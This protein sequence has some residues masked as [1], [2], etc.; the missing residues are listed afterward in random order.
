VIAEAIKRS[1]AQLVSVSENIDETPSGM[2]LHGI[3]ASIAEFYSLNLAAE[4]MKGTTEKA[5][6]GGTPGRPP[7]GYINAREM[8]DGREI[9]TIAIDPDRGQHIAAA[10]R[11]YSTGSYSLSELAG[12]LE[13]RGLR[14]RPRRRGGVPGQVA[15]NR[16]Q[17]ILRNDY[18]IGVLRYAGIV[19]VGRHPKLIDEPTF[20]RV[21]EILDSQRQSGERCWRHHS[22]LRGTVYCG[23]CGGRLIYTKATGR[24]GGTYEYL[25]CSRRLAGICAQPY[26]RLEAVEEA[27]AREYATIRLSGQQRERIRAAVRERVSSIEAAAEPELEELAQKLNEL[28]S[29][30]KKLLQ[31]HY[32]DNISPELFAA[33]QRR[34]RADRVA[35]EVRT[36]QLEADHS[37]ILACMETALDLTDRIEFAY[38]QADPV[39]RRLFNQA[40]FERIWIDRESV[41]GTELTSPMSEVLTI[42]HST[43][44]DPIHTSEAH[45]SESAVSSHRPESGSNP[46]QKRKNLHGNSVPWRFERRFYGAPERTRTSTDPTVHKP[47]KLARLPNSATSALRTAIIAVAGGAMPRC[48]GKLP[49]TVCRPRGPLSY[50]QMFVTDQ[51]EPEREGSVKLTR[52][53]R[54]ILEF[55]ERYC[56]LNGYPPTVRDIGKAVGLA[57]SST[58]HAHLANLEKLGMLRRDPTKPRAI[59][60]RGR[61]GG[62]LPRRLRDALPLVGQVAA[63]QPILAE[64]NIEE[65]VD[66]PAL[67]GGTEGDFLLRIRGESMKNAGILDGDVVVVRRQEI[68]QDGE[69]VVAVIED[70]ATVKRFYKEGDHIRL[71]PENEA[72]APILARDVQIAGKV[73]GLMRSF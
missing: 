44:V 14:S 50:E 18:Y 8:V 24:G 9:K 7:L 30:E 16:L 73:V 42:S 68:A 39:T 17:A 54:E 41:S 35:A 48:K 69:I 58:V 2:L 61:A 62:E 27:V 1:G 26:H 33:E 55:I 3:M 43:P 71:Q 66:A 12:I 20:Q 45:A 36:S 53:Q 28:A 31:A 25:V 65:Y 38:R 56:E 19:S 32:D 5:R 29:Q 67:A 21:Q 63:G 51:S 70:E 72:M 23:Q 47:L 22:Y 40:I 52:R 10:F 57:S 46:G 6:R 11:L 34:I 13:E 4:V 49:I 59:E 60:L 37:Q 64:E 15:P